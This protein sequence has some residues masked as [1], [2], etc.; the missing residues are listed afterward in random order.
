MRRIGYVLA[1]TL[2]LLA[3]PFTRA[4]EDSGPPLPDG[5]KTSV[6]HSKCCGICGH[7]GDC[8][9]KCTVICTT[10]NRVKT[11]WQVKE[12][13]YCN[14]LPSLFGCRECEVVK[15]GDGEKGTPKGRP[16][17]CGP[18]RTKKVLVKK[19]IVEKVPVYKCVPAY[20]CEKC[21][22]EGKAFDEP[23]ESQVIPTP[24]SPPSAVPPPPK[25]AI[26][27]PT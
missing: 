15:D 6:G 4:D 2:F 18:V 20:A 19:E 25:P 1:A 9:P 21:V 5:S 16:P 11:V 26:N 23:A 27:R 10:K 8:R 22:K 17:K 14:P 7:R 12:E 24:A 3:V 13:E